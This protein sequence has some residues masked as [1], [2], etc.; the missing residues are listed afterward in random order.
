MFRPRI[1]SSL[2]SAFP[3]CPGNCV[4]QCGFITDSSLLNRFLL[5]V[6]V[7]NLFLA[8]LLSS[9]SGDNLAAP[10]EEGE[11]N[12]QIAINRISRAV[13]WMKSWV[14][15]HVVQKHTHENPDRF[16]RTRV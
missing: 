9:F 15:G 3:L 16:G 7:L 4:F 1:R 2:V 8:L 14:M 10:E 6:Q 13:A 12:L 5:L 11:N